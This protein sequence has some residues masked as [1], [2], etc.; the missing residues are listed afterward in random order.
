MCPAENIWSNSWPSAGREG[1]QPGAAA[2]SEER[3]SRCQQPASLRSPLA[4]IISKGAQTPAGLESGSSPRIA[5]PPAPLLAG[6]PALGPKTQ[7]WGTG[8]GCR[9]APSMAPEARDLPAGVSVPPPCAAVRSAPGSPP[10][11]APAG[12][13]GLLSPG[14][15]E[16]GPTAP[17]PDAAHSGEATLRCARSDSRRGCRCVREHPPSSS[18][19]LTSGMLGA[20]SS[21]PGRGSSR[22]AGGAGLGTLLFQ[23]GFCPWIWKSLV[24]E[25]RGHN[26]WHWCDTERAA[27]VS[28]DRSPGFIS[29]DVLCKS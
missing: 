25:A 14:E 29:F 1:S 20:G 10:R 3:V 13:G 7:L 4:F 2:R 18:R 27:A 16:A 21:A 23:E 15:R 8:W 24:S 22:R 26:T 9:A 17:A 12:I 28:L 11:C 19:E 6:S 5:A